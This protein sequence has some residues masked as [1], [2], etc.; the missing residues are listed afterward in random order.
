MHRSQPVQPDACDHD[1]ERGCY[2]RAVRGPRA[3]RLGGARSGAALLVAVAVIVVVIYLYGRF[4]FTNAGDLAD[5]DMGNH[6]DFD[7]FRSSVRALWAGDDPYAT[8]NLNSPAWTPLFSLF[9]PFNAIVGF[10]LF[11]LT[12]IA[13]MLA[14]LTWTASTLSLSTRVALV[15]V[16]ALMLSGPMQATLH[17][18]QVYTVLALGLVAAWQ[19]ERGGRTTASAVALG[20]VA[21]LKPSLLPMLLWPAVHGRWRDLAAGVG[22]AAGT[23]GLGVLL[24]GPTAT[25]AWAQKLLN[26]GRDGSADNMSLEAVAYRL[27]TPNRFSGYLAYAPGMATAASLFAVILVVVTLLAARRNDL[28]LWALVAACLMAAP[29]A[30]R[31]YLVLLAPAV[32]VL[33]STRRTQAVGWLLLALQLI[34]NSWP[35]L[36]ED[37][38]S[39]AATIGLTLPCATLLAHW[40]A[41]LAGSH[42]GASE[43]LAHP[44][45]PFASVGEPEKANEPS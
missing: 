6:A 24:G 25:I 28:G 35:A 7:S 14:A 42:A 23:A 22:G 38:G 3:V 33:L 26:Y 17:Q 40:A 11:A 5:P 39:L 30:W 44:R 12:L 4:G 20:V 36:W 21:A 32:L 19:L 43:A 1:A 37:H 13:T 34:P 2:I 16:S 27:F 9:A 45:A 29:I 31:G 15:A 10:R 8:G 41:I 18:G